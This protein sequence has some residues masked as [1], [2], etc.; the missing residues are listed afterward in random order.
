MSQI[1]AAKT[2]L[3]LEVNDTLN[4]QQVT[5]AGLINSVRPHQTK[6]GDPMAFVEIEDLQ[7]T[8]EIVVF[9]KIYATSKTLLQ[10]GSLVVIRGKV[11]APEGRQPKVLADSI[12]NELVFYGAVGEVPPAS[13][14]PP[15][16]P[17]PPPAPS[18]PLFKKATVGTPN[19][20]PSEPAPAPAESGNNMSSVAEK[21]KHQ[22]GY[23]NGHTKPVPAVTAREASP[24]KAETEQRSATPP[25]NG[26]R[27]ET[28]S[29]QSEYQLHITMSRS[30]DLVKDRH[31]LKMIFDLLTEI[32]GDDEFSIYIPSGKDHPVRVDFPRHK[33]RFS[34]KLRAELAY[35]VGSTAIRVD[36]KQCPTSE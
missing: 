13:G 22:N 17:D 34:E 7:A 35:I 12:T 18:L 8:R 23:S 21:G 24:E 2:T 36:K 32:P 1:K 3:L 26:T 28:D 33:I 6:K 11:D 29:G 4:G 16:P 31:Q 25:D 5:V 9:P 30:G 27:I 20:A 15:V 14:A 10:N 19:K